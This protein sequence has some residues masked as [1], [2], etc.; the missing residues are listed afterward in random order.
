MKKSHQIKTYQNPAG[1][2]TGYD[3][4]IETYKQKILSGESAIQERKSALEKLS[5]AEKPLPQIIIRRNITNNNSVDNNFATQWYTQRQKSRPDLV[6]EDNVNYIK[7]RLSTLQYTNP[8]SVA[9]RA[10]T[11]V[12]NNGRVPAGFWSQAPEVYKQGF[13]GFDL[14]SH[15]QNGTNPKSVAASIYKTL[16]SDTATGTYYPSS[17][18]ININPNVAGRRGQYPIDL[19]KI[20]EEAH[21]YQ[22]PFLNQVAEVLK[23]HGKNPSNYADQAQEVHSRLMTFRKDYKLDPN[24]TYTLDDIN[25]FKQ[26]LYTK[27][28]NDGF[29]D[30][31]ETYHNHQLLNDYSD[32]LILDLLNNVASNNT[33]NRFINSGSMFPQ[34][35]TMNNIPRGTTFAKRGTKL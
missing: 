8:E 28:E 15:V 20:H 16:V 13:L 33:Q 35:N 5:S 10:E 3:A 31:A 22:L 2:L 29:G 1:P 9:A 23:K 21:A 30:S 11:Y 12:T 18:I 7:D 34:Q 6:T 19:T 32:E 26:M 14:D 27:K 25:T 24:K 4:E 17:H